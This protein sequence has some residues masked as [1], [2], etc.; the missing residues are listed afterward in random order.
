MGTKKTMV[1]MLWRIVA[2]S[3]LFMQAAGALAQSYTFGVLN[4]RSPALTAQYWNPILDFVG[5][6]TGINLAMRMGKDVQETDEATRRG[7]YDFVYTNHVVFTHENAQPGYKIILRP[8]EDAIKGQIVVAEA[9]PL[10]AVDDLRGKE[11]GF[12][13]KTAFVGYMVPMDF[14]MRTG[15]DVVPMFGGNQEGVMAQLKAGAVAAASVNSKVMRDYADR[16]GF[17]YRV[18]WSS[19]DYLNLPISVHPRVPADVV[20]RVRGAFDNMD[21]TP[22]GVAILKA[23]GEVIHQPPPYG[24]RFATDREYENY[25]T[26]YKTTVLKDATP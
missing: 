22:E 21:D 8:N 4:Q 17:R 12:P 20:A 3:A 2:I 13:S 25:R 7:E 15:I 10:K 16:T 24:F 14:L 11:V 1:H 9:S 19:P 5:K 23:S 18:L 6:K 26:F